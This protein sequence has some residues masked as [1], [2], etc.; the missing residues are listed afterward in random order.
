MPVVDFLRYAKFV[1]EGRGSSWD[2]PPVVLKQEEKGRHNA[3]IVE[4]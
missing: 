1:K 2:V 4:K 3:M